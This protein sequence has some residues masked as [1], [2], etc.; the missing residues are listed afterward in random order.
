[1]AKQM[2]LNAAEYSGKPC[3]DQFD[4]PIGFHLWHEAHCCGTCQGS[5]EVEVGCCEIKLYA[6]CDDCEGTGFRATTPG[7]DR[8]L[9]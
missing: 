6:D 7:A 1:M 5:G 3:P 8:C 9:S 4:D 2:T